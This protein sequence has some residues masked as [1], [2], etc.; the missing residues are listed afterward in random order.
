MKKKRLRAGLILA[1]AG[2]ILIVAFMWF[3]HL[4]APMP[5]G[6]E[7]LIR[8]EK[9]TPL[10]VALGELEQKGVVRSAKAFSL[11]A[12]L[13]RDSAP[14][15]VGTYSLTPGMSAGEILDALRKPLKQM[16]RL[17]IHWIADTAK[18]LE[19]HNVAKAAD[20]VALCK[21]PQAFQKYVKFH[22][23]KTGT[24]EGYLYPDTYDLPPLLGAKNTIVRQLRRFQEKVIG[25]GKE[26]RD[27]NRLLTVASMIQMEVARDDERPIVAGVIENRL[28]LG[29]RLQI[30]ATCLYANQVWKAPKHSDLVKVDS[31][32]NTYLHGGLPPGPICSPSLASI[33]AAKQPGNNNYLYYVALPGPEKRSLFASTLA[34]HAANIRKRKQALK[35]HGT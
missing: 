26:P 13:R 11:Y 32:Y 17:P 24:L 8:W 16:V 25:T 18:V 6:A 5:A 4:L 34:E 10:R 19:D 7:V 29:M 22:L 14:V 1:E 3:Q 20:Y 33:L 2:V 21:Q 27:L 23:P 30:D 12:R 9:R 31:P 15:A 35:G 28:R